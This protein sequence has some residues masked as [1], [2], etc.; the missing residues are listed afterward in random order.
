MAKSK[1]TVYLEQAMLTRKL[2]QAGM[3]KYAFLGGS[4]LKNL[5][6]L[7]ETGLVDIEN[8]QEPAGCAMEIWDR[9]KSEYEL[10]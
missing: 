6:F 5:I 3:E 7:A 1:D 10:E 8:I 2:K 4:N 9:I